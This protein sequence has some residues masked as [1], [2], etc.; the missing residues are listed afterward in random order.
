[1]KKNWRINNKPSNYPKGSDMTNT[2]AF[3]ITNTPQYE[4]VMVI[5][6]MISD[7]RLEIGM[8]EEKDSDQLE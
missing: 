5:N 7:Q 3:I 2:C 8:N 4:L 6:A 1:M